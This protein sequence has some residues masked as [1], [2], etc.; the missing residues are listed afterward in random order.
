MV[1]KVE[2]LLANYHTFENKTANEF[3]ISNE[4]L[5]LLVKEGIIEKVDHGIY[6]KSGESIDLL[7]VHQ[8]RRQLIYSHDTALYLHNLSD[9]EPL[10]YSATVSSGYH[11]SKIKELGIELYYVKKE[12]LS[13]GVAT[14]DTAFG[15]TVRV[16]SME[17]TLCDTIRNKGRM[18]KE[19]IIN[20]FKAY[21]ERKDKDL[22]ELKR[23]SEIFKVNKGIKS[24]LE[25]LL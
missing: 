12:L 11:S 16:Y 13:L 19:L 7:Y 4:R 25:I 22:N 17:R 20:A 10:R 8:Q 23:L 6:V 5:N 2:K 1:N 14:T 3:G 24:Y 9:R 18:D 15:N 21:V